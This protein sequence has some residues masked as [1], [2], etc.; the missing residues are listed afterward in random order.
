MRDNDVQNATTLNPST[1]L[2][3]TQ[4]EKFQNDELI[5]T[6]QNGTTCYNCHRTLYTCCCDVS[7]SNLEKE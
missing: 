3:G 4:F 2:S 1:G 5:T 6:D 7:K